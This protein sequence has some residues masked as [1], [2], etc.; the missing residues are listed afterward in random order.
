MNA[1]RG[2]LEGVGV[3]ITR[4]EPA[5]QALAAPL[6]AEGARVWRLPALAIEEIAPSRELEELLANLER[7]D[8]AIFVSANAVERGLDA[9]RRHGPWPGAIRV[10]AVGEATAQALRNSGIA[11]VISPTER[12]DSEGL[13]ALEPLRDV[14]GRNI[15]VFRGRGGREHLKETLEARGARVEYA[16][17]YARVRPDADAD[18][19]VGAL[20]RGEVQAVSALS[21]E[22]L[23]NFIAMIGPEGARHLGAVTLVV[24]H[25]AVGAHRDARRFARVAVAAHGVEGLIDA[26]TAVRTTP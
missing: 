13:L 21:A 7:F 5:A 2:K 12:H 14:R 3:V 23:E 6:A 17:C 16:E 18:A 24:G 26:L 19:V 25:A 9:A 8:L 1:R 15:V 20:A 22:T 10:A 11:D 4:P